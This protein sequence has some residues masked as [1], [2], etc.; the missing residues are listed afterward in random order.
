MRARGG[1]GVGGFG[2]WAAGER[3][4]A[5]PACSRAQRWGA[6]GAC[7]RGALGACVRGVLGASGVWSA[8]CGVRRGAA[9]ACACGVRCAMCGVR[10]AVCVRGGGGGAG[11]WLGAGVRQRAHATA[12]APSSLATASQKRASAAS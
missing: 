3:G 10:R 8:L 7:V 9:C 2:V 4:G 11:A 5:G 6:L 12:T 1:S